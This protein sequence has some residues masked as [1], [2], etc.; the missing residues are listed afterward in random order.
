[1]S[2]LHSPWR[3][4]FFITYSWGVVLG[5]NWIRFAVHRTNPR[6]SQSPLFLIF[7]FLCPLNF[8]SLIF[9]FMWAQRGDT[10]LFLPP[11]RPTPVP[12]LSATSSPL[13]CCFL[14]SICSYSISFS[15]TYPSSSHSPFSSLSWLSPP[16]SS[17]LK[18]LPRPFY[19]SAHAKLLFSPSVFCDMQLKRKKSFLIEWIWCILHAIQ[20]YEQQPAKCAFYYPYM[21]HPFSQP[22]PQSNFT[23]T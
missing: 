7:F 22:H 23:E 11:I 12:S 4:Y 21:H 1:M 3:T 6:I 5:L 14:V 20:K 17:R 10:L 15:S 8:A 16:L 13:C 19:P 2:S 9:V 18:T